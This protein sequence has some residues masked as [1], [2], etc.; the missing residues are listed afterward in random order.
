MPPKAELPNKS[1]PSLAYEVLIYLNSFYIAMYASCEVGM[2]LLKLINLPYPW[3]KV[4]IDT[5]VLVGLI[6]FEGLRCF[7][8][9]RGRLITKGTITMFL[10]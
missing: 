9:R 10:S 4:Q 2:H 3:E 5:G 7:M 8:G 1:N 6:L